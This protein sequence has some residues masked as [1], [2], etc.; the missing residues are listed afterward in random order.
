MN[1]IV[2]AAGKGTRMK[3]DLY[4]V[5]HPVCGK[6]MVSHVLHTIQESGIEN[7]VTV[8]GH[9]AEKVKEVIGNVSHFVFQ[10]EQ[11]GTAHAVLQAKDVLAH[12]KGITIV[13]CGDTPLLTKET[14][15]T[16]LR[17]HNETKAKATILTAVAE[18]PM[19]Y[20]RIIRDSSGNVMKIVEQKDTNEQ[21]AAVKEI[22]TGTYCFDNELLFNVLSQV[23]TN[24]SQGEYYLTDVIELLQKES[25]IV[26]AY[27]TLDFD[28]T[29]GV[30]DR[31][32]LS[33]AEVHMQRRILENHMKNGVTIINPMNT[34]IESDVIIGKDTVIYPGCMIKGHSVIGEYCEIGMNTEI[35]DGVIGDYSS[36]KQSVVHDS[37]IGQHVSVG[38]FAHI[39]PE[40]HVANHVRLGNFV[41]TKKSKIG[42]KSKVSHLSYIGDAEI[43]ENVNVGCGSITVNY[44]G[45]N[46]H[47]TVIEDGTFIGCNSNLVA[48]VTV[49]KNSFVAA[50]STIT[51]DVPEHALAFGRAKQVNKE[52]YIKK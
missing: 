26:S 20:G 51:K 12:K 7:V 18:N 40:T 35:K 38:P 42:E 22:N 9:G 14:I 43:G 39:R 19:G 6:P 52:G 36:I 29:L 21:E 10:E 50:G 25:H 48:P 11:L 47:K 4:K 27:Q 44:D 15:S 49:K 33:Q 46:K 31:I 8:V 5:L 17:Y 28:E 16:L 13:M 1:A 45:K 24:N 23:S 30:N 37:S 3:S 41:E 2:L 32:A 34:Y